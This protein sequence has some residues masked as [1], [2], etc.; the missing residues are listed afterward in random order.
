M[1]TAE[2]LLVEAK[3]L[4]ASVSFD[5]NSSAARED[6]ISIEELTMLELQ[7]DVAEWS[8][9]LGV[10]TSLLKSLADGPEGV[11]RNI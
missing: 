3:S 5:D 9:I 7:K 4:R 6:L 11:A 8:I 2:A 10:A 1:H